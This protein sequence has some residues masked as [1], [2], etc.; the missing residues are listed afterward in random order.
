MVFYIETGV[1]SKA[2]SNILVVEQNMNTWSIYCGGLGQG[3]EVVSALNEH[4][5]CPLS[6]TNGP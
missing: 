1:R 5:S 4:T 2:G 3:Q 6:P